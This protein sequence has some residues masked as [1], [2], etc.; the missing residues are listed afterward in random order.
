MVE[1]AAKSM[2]KIDIAINA[3]G[4][5]LTQAFQKTTEYDLDK[6]LALQ[7]KGP[8]FFMQ[9]LIPIMKA[10]GGGSII[11][12][13]SGTAVLATMNHNAYAGT[14]AGIDHVVRASP[15]NLGSITFE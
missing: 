15:M 2:G 9:S 5:G 6:M 3:T 8:Y 11:Q 1:S 7:F 4:W 10:S 14:K 13:S 12:I